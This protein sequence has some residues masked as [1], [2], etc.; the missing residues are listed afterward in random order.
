[1]NAKRFARSGPRLFKAWAVAAAI[2]VAVA[3]GFSVAPIRS[4]LERTADTAGG[5]PSS[6]QSAPRQ[7]ALLEVG[8]RQAAIVAGPPLVL[9]WFGWDLW[10]AVLGFLEP[11]RDPAEET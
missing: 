9:L 4:A 6:A 11:K 3:I 2:Y 7:P 5:P 1:L 10:F 8:A